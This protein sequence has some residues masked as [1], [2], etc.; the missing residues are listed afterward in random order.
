MKGRKR[1]EKV[2]SKESKVCE[3]GPLWSQVTRHLPDDYSEQLSKIMQIKTH[4]NV[5]RAICAQL[6]HK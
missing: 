5:L 2:Q 6:T 4:L 1:A 3:D